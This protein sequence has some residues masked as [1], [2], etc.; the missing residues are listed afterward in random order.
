MPTQPTA[1]LCDALGDDARVVAPVFKDFGGRRAFSG[2]IATVR[3]PEDNSMVREA[4]GEPG[5]GRVLVVEGHGSTRYALLGGNLAV[6]AQKNG[7]A[8][9]VVHGCV[10]DLAELAECDIGVRA[11][12]A[13]PRRSEKLGRGERDLVVTFAG[14]SFA[15]GEWLCADA[16]GMV[17]C[18]SQPGT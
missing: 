18:R 17:V 1:D 13:I 8:G 4:L 9:V 12:N 16:D 11:L 10:R 3:A 6:L 5:E 14:V 7:W 15:P 2:R